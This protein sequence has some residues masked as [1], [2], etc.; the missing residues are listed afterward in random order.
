MKFL[1]SIRDHSGMVPGASGH[2]KTFKNLQI[3]PWEGLGASG[4]NLK[5][6]SENIVLNDFL[7]LFFQIFPCW[8]MYCPCGGTRGFFFSLNKRYAHDS[9]SRYCSRV[10]TAHAEKPAN[11]RHRRKVFFQFCFSIFS[12]SYRQNLM[13]LKIAKENQQSFQNLASDLGLVG[14][15]Y[16]FFGKQVELLGIIFEKFS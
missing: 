7:D 13:I 3:F 2:R 8:R 15:T 12:K 11:L 9:Q 16:E 1:G 5:N 6:S 4:K 10:I 14:Y